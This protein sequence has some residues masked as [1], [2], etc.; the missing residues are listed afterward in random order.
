LPQGEY[1][2]HVHVEEQQGGASYF[3]R[4]TVE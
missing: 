4:I 2:V 3:L 1:V